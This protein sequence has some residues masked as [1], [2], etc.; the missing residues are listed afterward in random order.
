MP[1][2][3]ST[4]K[5]MSPVVSQ[6]KKHL[7]FLAEEEEENLQSF[8]ES[9]G[10]GQFNT[11]A[12]GFNF[13]PSSDSIFRMMNEK[14]SKYLGYFH[15][16]NI[17]RENNAISSSFNDNFLVRLSG[18]HSSPAA[19]PH[20]DEMHGTKEGPDAPIKTGSVDVDS[21]G[22]RETFSDCSQILDNFEVYRDSGIGMCIVYS[23]VHTRVLNNTQLQPRS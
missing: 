18:K 11:S 12:F 21:P 15:Q 20:Q 7:I 1:L 10:N 13:P 23:F 6:T 3:D 5:G 8:S 16:T 19:V 17:I 22:D 4:L 9:P 2:R 14:L